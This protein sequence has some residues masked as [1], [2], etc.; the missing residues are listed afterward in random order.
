MMEINNKSYDDEDDDGM[1]Q[2][3]IVVVNPKSEWL[4]DSKNITLT[5]L[6]KLDSCHDD[7]EEIIFLLKISENILLSFWIDMMEKR[8]NVLLIWIVCLFMILNLKEI[9]SRKKFS[10]LEEENWIFEG[11]WWRRF[12]LY[13]F[14]GRG[15]ARGR[16]STSGEISEGNIGPNMR[17]SRDCYH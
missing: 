11:W 4:Y 3:E 17:R 16:Q 6:Q 12:T 8:I 7:E 1:A 2:T 10:T 9:D 15:L 13:D 5:I 14:E